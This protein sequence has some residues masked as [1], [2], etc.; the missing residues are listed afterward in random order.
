MSKVTIIREDGSM[1]LVQWTD[2]KEVPQRNWVKQSMIRMRSGKDAEVDHPEHGYPYGVDFS[3]ALNPAV[4]SHDICR[5]LRKRGLWT[6]DDLQKSPQ[7]IM[8]ALQAAYGLDLS[9]IIAIARQHERLV[10]EE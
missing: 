7:S 4:T 1:S 10:T 5:E 2:D 9:Q 3:H 8:G 6:V